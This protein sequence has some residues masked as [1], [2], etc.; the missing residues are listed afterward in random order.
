MCSKGKFKTLTLVK[1][2]KVIK[3]V[4]IGSRMKKKTLLINFG[5]LLELSRQF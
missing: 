1:K 2:V 5:F 4:I 3:T